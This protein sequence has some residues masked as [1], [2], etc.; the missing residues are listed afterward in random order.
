LVIKSLDPDWIRI[1]I[2]IQRKMLDPESM[3]PDP[4]PLFPP[5]GWEG[6]GKEKL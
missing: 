4:K 3:N 6:R 1:R 5:R 2:A